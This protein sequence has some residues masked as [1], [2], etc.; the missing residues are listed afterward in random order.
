MADHGIWHLEDTLTRMKLFAQF[1]FVVACFA[2]W[3]C[4]PRRMLIEISMV[5]HALAC[6]WF[7]VG[8]ALSSDSQAMFARSPGR[9]DSIVPVAVGGRPFDCSLTFGSCAP[10]KLV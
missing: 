8:E 5:V 7:G 1:G 4:Y 6:I 3:A 9:R 2:V 10:A